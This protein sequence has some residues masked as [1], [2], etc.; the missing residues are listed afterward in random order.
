MAES[1]HHLLLLSGLYGLLRPLEPIQLYSCPLKYQIAEFWDEDDLLT[2]VFCE[3]IRNQRIA[4]V[5]DLTAM[6]AYRKLI[7]YRPGRRSPCNLDLPRREE[8]V[9]RRDEN[10]PQCWTTFTL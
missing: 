10:L 8:R 6:D 2:D 1:K 9:Q 4:K 3:Y 5:I 7:I